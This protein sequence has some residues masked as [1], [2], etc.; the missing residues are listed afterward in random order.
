M[1][2]RQII[3]L[4]GL[5]LLPL[6]S[7]ICQQEPAK[8][9]SSAPQSSSGSTLD[10]RFGPTFSNAEGKAAAERLLRALGGPATVNAVKSLRQSVVAL[11]QGQRIEVDQSIV[12]PDKQAQKVITPQGKMLLVITPSDAFMAV[13]GQVQNLRYVQRTSLDSALKHDPVNVLQHIND[14]KYIFTATGQESLDGAEATVVD[15]EADGVPTRWWI[16]AD[17]RLL[18]ERSSG[19]GGKIQTMVYS[20]WKNFGGLRYPTKYEVYSEGGKPVL[21]MTLTT[22]EVNPVVSPK[23]FQRPSTN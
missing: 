11:Q 6:C 9:R 18:R 8:P 20:E 3:C 10:L 2:L 22:M 7:L 16:G 1:T 13:G 23:L 17:G 21:S 4:C 5:T 19:E 15:V 14:P 12:Y